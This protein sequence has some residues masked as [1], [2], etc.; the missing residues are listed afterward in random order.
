MALSWYS[1]LYYVKV[2]KEF[3]LKFNHKERSSKLNFKLVVSHVDRPQ[4]FEGVVGETEH[5]LFLVEF[6][7]Q[8]SW[9]IFCLI[10]YDLFVSSGLEMVS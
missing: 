8:L 3:L 6:P 10:W 2:G 7:K 5:T 1:S 4:L 9:C